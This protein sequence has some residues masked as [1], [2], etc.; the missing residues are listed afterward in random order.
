MLAL[1][2]A[3]GMGTRMGSL[4]SNSHKGLLQVEGRTLLQHAVANLHSRG[5]KEVHVVTGH[6]APLIEEHLGDSATCVFN[7]FFK[8]AGILASFWQV[9]PAFAGKPFVFTFADH[10]FTPSL[11][12]H[13]EPGEWDLLT[14]VQQ[15][16]QYDAED[17]KVRMENGR[18]ARF[19]KDIPLDQTGGE[20]TGLTALSARGSQA[21][22]DATRQLLENGQ[23]KAYA[24]DALNALLENR[25]IRTAFR[26]CD[27]NARIEIDSV[28]D[29]R[30]ARKLAK[31]ILNETGTGRP[32]RKPAA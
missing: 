19:G 15:K 11:L 16:P 27:A 24:M 8:V 14:V 23:I 18:L 32:R 17:S 7:P 6:Q 5:Y 29:L 30:R 28:A 3:A 25:D 31:R 21:F 20:Y 2:P 13:C 12:D 4:T 10:F 1:I 22:F 9:L 26:S